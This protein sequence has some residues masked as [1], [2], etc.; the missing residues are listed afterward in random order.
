MKNEINRTKSQEVAVERRSQERRSK[1]SPGYTLV[2]AV[3]WYCRRY[4]NRRKVE[5]EEPLLNT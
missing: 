4:K 3:G 1:E 2:A 5:I